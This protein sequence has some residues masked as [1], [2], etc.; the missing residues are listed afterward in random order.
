[1]AHAKIIGYGA[2]L[3]QKILSNEE[4]SKNLDTNDEWIFSRTGIKNRH[5]AAENE[6]TSDLAAHALKAALVNAQLDASQLDGI[7]LATT[8]PDVV[9]PSTATI[10]QQKVE[11]CNAF[12]FD[13][14]AVCSGFVYAL[15]VANAM[16]YTP[17]Y[18]R[19]AIIGAETMSRIVD[20]NDR[21]TCILFGDGAG[22]IILERCDSVE[23]KGIIAI[24]I[25]SDGNCSD[26]LKVGG[27]VSSGNLEAKLSMNGKEVFKHAVEKMSQSTHNMLQN[28]NLTEEDI[29]FIIPHQANIR[30]I[31]A[32][33][34]RLGIDE[35]KIISTVANHANTSAASIP[36]AFA[37]G[38][39]S[40]RLQR[41]QR[42]MFTALGAGLTWGS[43]LIEL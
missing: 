43:A 10:V 39:A 11:A 20:W 4:L 2:Y 40:N 42:I 34:Q 35:A 24:D 22:T 19:I 6:Y 7:I 18:K 26:I 32:I 37:E 33:A 30:I 5:I 28:N 21:S 41:G 27:G 9:F 12:A 23:E 13:I 15:S 16:L 17:Q 3:P 29:D 25:A 8:T 31:N 38:F 1:M 36:L 14:S